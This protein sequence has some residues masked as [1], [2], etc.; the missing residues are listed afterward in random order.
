MTEVIGEKSE[1]R[2]EWSE[3]PD[4]FD[5]ADKV[6]KE[7]SAK[8]H[9]VS[10]IE[11]PQKPTTDTETLRFTGYQ[12]AFEEAEAILR[13]NEQLSEVDDEEVVVADPE[14]EIVSEEPEESSETSL[15][16]TV[17]TAGGIEDTFAKAEAI[18]VAHEVEKELDKLRALRI[19]REQEN[20]QGPK[21]SRLRRARTAMKQ[22][23]GDLLRRESS[24]TV[25]EDSAL[26]D[27]FDFSTPTM[28]STLD[29]SDSEVLPV[30]PSYVESAHVPEN[31]HDTAYLY[32]DQ[33]T[34]QVI[35]VVPANSTSPDA[36]IDCDIL[37][38]NL[39]RILSESG[40]STEL[41]AK[42]RIELDAG[43]ENSAAGAAIRRVYFGNGY[44]DWATVFASNDSGIL[45][46]REGG[47]IER[48]QS[49]SGEAV[50][51]IAMFVGSS[52]DTLG[53]KAEAILAVST[54]VLDLN[55][56]EIRQVVA[57]HKDTDLAHA[58]IEKTEGS[59][60]TVAVIRDKET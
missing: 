49:E 28:G 13:A 3:L 34:N 29:F 59:T 48:Y 6:L 35:S 23:I 4:L 14:P 39:R 50:A 52:D 38:D 55:D 42:L 33:D 1:R 56:D 44:T 27:T 45:V 60:G 15:E 37:G 58:L 57:E 2:V 30:Y 47:T 9:V 18:L 25:E 36:R 53:Q 17:A 5:L 43:S 46:V 40:S 19:K 20:A 54:D 32:A 22:S 41:T 24:E 7:A 11:K 12:S 31:E 10:T 51:N 21:E 8:P 26:G 16:E